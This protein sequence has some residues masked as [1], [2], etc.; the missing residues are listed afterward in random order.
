MIRNVQRR[1][2]HLASSRPIELIVGVF[3]LV[4]L[5]YFQLLHAVTHSNFFEPL[6]QEVNRNH[7][8]IFV[9]DEWWNFSWG[10]DK[11][12]SSSSTSGGVISNGIGLD[13]NGDGMVYVLKAGSKDWIPLSQLLIDEDQFNL[14]ETA[15]IS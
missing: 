11:G 4:T 10:A 1:L 2:A 15:S 5:A 7:N 13:S 3:C 12:S 8:G 6:N 14:D 9:N